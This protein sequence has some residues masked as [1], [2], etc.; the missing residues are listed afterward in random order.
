MGRTK[1]IRTLATICALIA[2]CGLAAQPD[3]AQNYDDWVYYSVPAEGAEPAMHVVETARPAAGINVIYSCEARG[4]AS[5]ESM[6]L[7]NDGFAQMPADARFDATFTFARSGQRAYADAVLTADPAHATLDVE[8][9]A[10]PRVLNHMR[11]HDAFIITEGDEDEAVTA[12]A[13]PLPG[14]DRALARA[15]HTCK[16]E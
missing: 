15:Q 2:S 12:I 6:M 14:F 8:T 7:V 3:A 5:R 9:A 11:N 13:I 4:D 10:L 1:V 16:G